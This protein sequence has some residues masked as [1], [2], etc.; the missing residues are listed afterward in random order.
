MSELI[1][2]EKCLRLILR[3]CRFLPLPLLLAFFTADSLQ[4]QIRLDLKKPKI[5]ITRF[6]AGKRVQES[7]ALLATESIKMHLLR[8]NIFLVL[9]RED[10]GLL[11][12]EQSL[13][14]SGVLD[15]DERSKIGRMLS[16][17]HVVFGSVSKIKKNY[18]L[19]IKIVDV[20][21]GALVYS[22][23]ANIKDV[24]NIQK[25][26]ENLVAG[27]S[28]NYAYYITRVG[29]SEKR[30]IGT[31]GKTVNRKYIMRLPRHSTTL[32]LASVLAPGAAHWKIG[33]HFWGAIYGLLGGTAVINLVYQGQRGSLIEKRE[34]AHID[35]LETFYLLGS[36]LNPNNQV[37]INSTN[38]QPVDVLKWQYLNKFIDEKQ[39]AARTRSSNRFVGNFLLIFPVIFAS[40][41]DFNYLRKGDVELRGRFLSDRSDSTHLGLAFTVRF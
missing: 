20:E 6:R 23:I 34:L 26:C 2:I 28:R 24:D 16:V 14:E 33:D 31:G 37:F 29:P 9:E 18:L 1:T 12:K 17:D 15:V 38:L 21:S 13:N 36:A 30:D 32:R 10:I 11:F 5:A 8:T 22:D 41:L 27:I 19:T 4:A 7:I 40:A 25:A 3:L 39:T 35:N